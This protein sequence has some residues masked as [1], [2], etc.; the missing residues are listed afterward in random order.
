LVFGK[1]YHKVLGVAKDADEDTIRRAYRRLALLF[2]PD[3]N[4]NAGAEARFKEINEAY[5]ILS[6]KEKPP[7]IVPAPRGR[8]RRGHAMTDWASE[9]MRVWADIQEEKF[10]NMYR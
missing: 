3:R 8:S 1:D 2:H 6:G 9:V 7:E 4:K 5:A 10:N